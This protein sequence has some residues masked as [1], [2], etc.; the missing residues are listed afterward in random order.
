MMADSFSEMRRAASVK[1]NRL[2]LGA[3]GLTSARRFLR[4]LPWFLVAQEPGPALTR[5]KPGRKK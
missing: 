5:Y 2:P 3:H 4:R 1:E